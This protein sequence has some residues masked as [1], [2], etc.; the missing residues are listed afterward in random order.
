MKNKSLK[1]LLSKVKKQSFRDWVSGL[2]E[3]GFKKTLREKTSKKDTGKPEYNQ[4]RKDNNRGSYSTEGLFFFLG[5]L[6]FGSA[7]SWHF[8][9]YAPGIAHRTR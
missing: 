8:C 4:D 5:L 3:S 9:F 2:G 6:A 7:Y 1:E